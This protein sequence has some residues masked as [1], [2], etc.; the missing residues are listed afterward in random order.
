[1]SGGVSALPN[2]WAA[3]IRAAWQS[4]VSG[5][6]ETGRLLVEAKEALPRGEFIAM[7][8]SELPFKRSTAFR[9]IAIS[10]DIRLLNGAHAHHLPPHWMT[11][12]EISRLDDETFMAKTPVLKRLKRP[13]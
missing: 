8:E 13:V 1:M 7:V 12:Y 9:L 4:S 2:S 5:I 3:R 11:L 10:S 6:L